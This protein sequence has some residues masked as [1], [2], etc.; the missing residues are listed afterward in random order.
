MPRQRC[1]CCGFA[2]TDDYELGLIRSSTDS[3]R[4]EIVRWCYGRALPDVAR[5]YDISYTTLER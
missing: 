4:R 2:F 3:F 5:E 1:T